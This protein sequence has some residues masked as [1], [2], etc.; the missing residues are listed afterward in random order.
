MTL[1]TLSRILVVLALVVLGVWLIGGTGRLTSETSLRQRAIQGFGPA[2]RPART[3]VDAASDGDGAGMVTG[4]SAVPSVV[5]FVN[6][7]APVPGKYL[8]SYLRG[9]FDLEDHVENI[10]TEAEI[11]RLIERS[12][13]RGVDRD[14]QIAETTDTGLLVNIPVNFLGLRYSNTIGLTPPDAEI[15]VGIDHVVEVV[16]STLA[17][18][19]KADGSIAAG[20]VDMEALF[21]AT[22]GAGGFYFDPVAVYDD[23]AD[24]Y[25]VSII[26]DE[27]S[28]NHF[29]I[30]ASQS[31]DPLGNWNVYNFDCNP[32]AGTNYFCDYHRIAAGQTAVYVTANMFGQSFVRNH[33]FAFEKA[34]MYAGEA[35]NFVKYDVG[36]NYFTLN[37]TKMLGHD[38]G[39][40]PS[41]PAEPHYIVTTPMTG[42]KVDIFAFSDP[43]G[44]P[45]LTLKASVTASSFGYPVTQQ[46]MGGQPITAN[47][48]RLLDAKYWGGHIWATQHVGCN[49]GSGTVN[50]V[51]WYELD[52]TGATP[53]LVQ[54]GTYGS[55]GDYR[56]FPDLAVNAC[57][58]MVVGY[59][60]MNASSYPSV[61]VAGRAARSRPGRLVAEA[62]VYAGEAAHAC[63]DAI[64]RRWGDYLDMTVDPVDGQTF[65]YVGQYSYTQPSC[66]W[67]TRIAAIQLRSCTP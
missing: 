41:N 19:N 10:Y 21:S 9:E 2:G 58:Q 27:G 11:Q 66:N 49:P 53:S 38:F 13:A 26:V 14:V 25:L 22:C 42:G 63:Y 56:S 35:A 12:L 39:G 64:P 31:S 40:W 44:T 62:Q 20:P 16:N 48:G 36:N 46:Q 54:S 45:S 7:P 59:T 61:Y 30:A 4:I 24:R 52:L 37:P 50:C 15:A 57:G 23:E 17:I 3:A 65:W 55:N 8:E 60:K 34:K 5:T 18:Y 47:D 1:R 32:G 6:G 29:C 43:W 51:R 67:A 33:V 28:A